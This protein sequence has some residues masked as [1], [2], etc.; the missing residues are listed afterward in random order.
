MILFNPMHF[1]PTNTG[2]ST[3]AVGLKLTN[4][5][6]VS[7]LAISGGSLQAWDRS[8]VVVVVELQ[9]RK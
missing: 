9:L 6:C 8:W 5:L 4:N 7:N 1:V 2:S 3:F